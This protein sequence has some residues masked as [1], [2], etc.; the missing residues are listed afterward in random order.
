ME[1]FVVLVIAGVLLLWTVSP[2]EARRA[3]LDPELLL[4][5]DYLLAHLD[6][7][8][9]IGPI[10]YQKDGTVEVELDGVV[11]QVK[12]RSSEVYIT[13]KDA[14]SVIGFWYGSYGWIFT[15]DFYTSL[16]RTIYMY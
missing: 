5:F 4:A 2:R 12:H 3:D 14:L 13:P 7:S 15:D 9:H 6:K 1:V 8:I 16:D 10:R 11:Y